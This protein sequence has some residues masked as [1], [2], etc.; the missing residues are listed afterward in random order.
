MKMI[1]IFIQAT[2]IYIISTAILNKIITRFHYIYYQ[3]EQIKIKKEIGALTL[4][5]FPFELRGW[6]I[7][8]L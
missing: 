1:I 2:F 5:S 6:D 4:K 8:K 7:E 3:F